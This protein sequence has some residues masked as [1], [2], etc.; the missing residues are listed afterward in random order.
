[1]FTVN[2]FHSRNDVEEVENPFNTM[3]FVDGFN[4]KIALLLV[5]L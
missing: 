4:K 2:A 1:M 3:K 5:S